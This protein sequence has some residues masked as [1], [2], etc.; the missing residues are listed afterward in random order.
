[1]LAL[2]MVV[3]TGLIGAPGLGRGLLTALSNHDVGAAFEAGLAIVILAI[4][5]DR[6]TFAAG[7]WLDPRVRRTQVRPGGRLVTVVVPLLI[8][9]AGLAAPF[10]V[11]ATQFPDAISV[12]LAEPVN[13][14]AGWVTDTFSPVTVAIKN[15]L[16]T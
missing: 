15:V 5:L 13:A 14:F 11:D 10:V 6:L 8:L 7:E 9:G 4:V 3:V 16:T 12:S 2:S 1:M